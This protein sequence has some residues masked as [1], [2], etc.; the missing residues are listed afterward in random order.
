MQILIGVIGPKESIER[1]LK[2]S[3]EFNEIEL[4]PFVYENL[5]EIEDIINQNKSF[6][7]QWLFSGIMNYTF[8]M[9]R[10]LIQSHQG[11]YPPLH[12]SSFF[13]I[14][15][16]AQLNEKQIFQRIS[17]DTVTD[18]EISKILSYYHLDSLN[19]YSAPYKGYNKLSEIAD[20][21]RSLFQKNHTEIAI[22][23]IKSIYE[24]LKKDGV[25][26]YRLTPSYLAI[27]L[28]IELLVKRAQTT[29]FEN[30]QMAIIGCSVIHNV[31]DNN[32]FYALFKW[33]HH[34][35][36]VKKSLLK[37][38]QKMNGSFVSLGDGFYF[39]FT[40]KGE[41]DGS[42][43]ELFKFMSAYITQETF[44]LRMAI[45]YGETV[46][47]AEQNV[48]YG[49]SQIQHEK[50]PSLLIID[51]NYSVTMKTPDQKNSLLSSKL[52]KE[53]IISKFGKDAPINHKDV[54]RIATYSYKYNK[55]EFTSQDVSRW[56]QSTERNARRILT[57][58][59][60]AGILIKCG[61][62]SLK[63]RGRPKI[64][65]QF[66]ENFLY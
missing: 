6:I 51:K 20:F 49:L 39:I 11:S 31:D 53:D 5:S 15:M 17:I 64:V 27:K 7:D 26:V 22:T 55:N 44:S 2:V 10:K 34:E 38:T 40:T 33:R 41:I 61:S 3:E 54:L 59:E 18:I 12:G 50:E 62:V 45:G 25:L 4:I 63:Q 36:D 42:E 57:E 21:H 65:Y 66:A 13:G 56:L 35:L 23:S 48:R 14:L 43:H 46:T 52:I 37:L 9:D 1:I 8:A 58:L 30:L 16:E 47:Q 29:R 19:Y 60:S 32:E 28:T 24:Q